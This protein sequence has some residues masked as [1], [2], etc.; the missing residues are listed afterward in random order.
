MFTRGDKGNL[1]IKMKHSDLQDNPM[2]IIN[3]VLTRDSASSEQ[4]EINSLISNASRIFKNIPDF[5]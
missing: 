4:K 3:T 2:I 5:N 1:V